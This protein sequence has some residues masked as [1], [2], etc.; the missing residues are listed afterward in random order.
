MYIYIYIRIYIYAHPTPLEPTKR[1]FLPIFTVKNNGFTIPFPMPHPRHTHTHIYIYS[2]I[3]TYYI[4]TI[5]LNSVSDSDILLNQKPNLYRKN[6][7][8][9]FNIK[10]KMNEKDLTNKY[11]DEIPATS[12]DFDKIFNAFSKIY[13]K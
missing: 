1:V 6:H 11:I 4:Y 7:I 2:I 10:G 8:K 3:Y 13:N 5:L 12:V 9:Y